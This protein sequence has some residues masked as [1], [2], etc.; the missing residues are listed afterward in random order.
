MKSLKHLTTFSVIWR[1]R[2]SNSYK[3]NKTLRIK[4]QELLEVEKELVVAK[5]NLVSLEKD[6]DRQLTIIE[7]IRTQLSMICWYRKVRIDIV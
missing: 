4:V 5:N 7:D 6:F 2:R 3:K 1:T